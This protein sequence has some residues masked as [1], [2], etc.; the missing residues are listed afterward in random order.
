MA[1]GATPR[2]VRAAGPRERSGP[3]GISSGDFSTPVVRK[4]T[5]TQPRG[6]PVL[7]TRV[8]APSLDEPVTASA[9]AAPVEF[10]DQVTPAPE[11][12]PPALEAAPE[13]SAAFAAPPE[14][15]PFPEME[16]TP[17]PEPTR[18]SDPSGPSV[19]GAM[20]SAAVE[21]IPVAMPTRPP[22]PPVLGDDNP[23]AGGGPARLDID[24]EAAALAAEAAAVRALDS[25]PLTP[26]PEIVSAPKTPPTESFRRRARRPRRSRQLPY[27]AA[28]HHGDTYAAAGARGCAEDAAARDRQHTDAGT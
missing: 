27:P 7:G 28:R 23:F 8:P 13:R 22:P 17:A 11:A 25:G 15:E 10:E 6:I 24:A 5:T 20:P 19:V 26:P 3:I 12:A 9:D 2:R 1:D 18:E 14:P 16:P 21:A 4:R